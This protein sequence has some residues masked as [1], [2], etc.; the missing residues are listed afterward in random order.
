MRISIRTLLTI[1]FLVLTLAPIGIVGWLFYSNSQKAVK[2]I[3]GDLFGQISDRSREKLQLYL[4]TPHFINRLNANSIELG[5]LNLEDSTTTERYFVEQFRAVSQIE[6]DPDL[7]PDNDELTTPINHLYIG[8]TEGEFIGAEYR[9]VDLSDSTT[10]RIFA[11]SRLED[12]QI[13]QYRAKRD[14]SAGDRLDDPQSPAPA[15]RFNLFERRWYEKGEKLWNIKREAGWSVPYCDNSTGLPAITAVRPIGLNNQLVGIL[16]SDFLFSDIEVFLDNLLSELNI[17]GGKIFILNR[18]H[19]ILVYSG[20][21][22]QIECNPDGSGDIELTLAASL[23]DSIISKLVNQGSVGQDLQSIVFNGQNHYWNSLEFEDNYG[24]QLSIFIVIPS[25]NF[26]GDIDAST[27]FTIFLSILTLIVTGILGLIIAKKITEP[28]LKLEKAAQDL[29]ISIG[30]NETDLNI[31]INNPSELHTLAAT[32][33]VMSTQLRD[34]FIA[35]RHFV[36]QNF[37]NSL[38]YKDATEVQLG[39]FK[40]AKMTILFS[41]IRSFTNLSE[42]MTPEQNF[43]FINSYLDQMEPAINSNNGFIDKYMGDGIMALFEGEQGAT[44]AV[45][46]S[47]GMLK[48]LNEYNKSRTTSERPPLKIGIGVHTGEITLGTLGGLN[49][50]DTTVIGGDV[51]RASRM[52]GLT[53]D[54]GAG[55]LVSK[56]TLNALKTTEFRHRYLGAASV[57]GLDEPVSIY[58]IF[59]ADPPAILECKLM[60]GSIFQEAVRLFEI[61]SYAQ[62]L[63]KFDEILAICPEDGAAAFYSRACHKNLG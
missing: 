33:D 35:F 38:G 45:K 1:P 44:N 26:T 9:P 29:V 19:E 10:E 23:Q 8:T 17:N 30:K 40:R 28:V 59:E 60:T 36:P 58:E 46:A 63:E 41:D 52:E 25:S 14:G 31:E 4:S 62:A 11:I 15:N 21:A 18:N 20:A 51:N 32:F 3:A 5:L 12:G 34:L 47:I 53:K 6:Q 39:D 43:R 48:R 37:L 54:F 22:Q 49:R 55:L 50:W 27:K 24:L 61:K 57:R 2:Q 7:L 16:G 13:I 56:Q 42:H